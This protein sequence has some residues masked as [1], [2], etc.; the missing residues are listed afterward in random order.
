MGCNRKE[1]KRGTR[2]TLG[3]KV[4]QNDEL[5]FEE[6]VKERMDFLNSILLEISH[7][8]HEYLRVNFEED[9]EIHVYPQF[10][11][12]KYSLAEILENGKLEIEENLGNFKIVTKNWNK[13]RKYNFY[14]RPEEDYIYYKELQ[15]K[16]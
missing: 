11:E 8:P 9:G 16:N 3:I 2:K 15:N 4:G 7:F 6:D 1:Y 14:E 12:V 5:F 10:S 13:F